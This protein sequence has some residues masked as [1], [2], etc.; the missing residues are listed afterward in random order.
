MDSL[1]FLQFFEARQSDDD[2]KR[3]LE[4][5]CRTCHAHLCDIEPGDTLDVLVSVAEIHASSTAHG[6]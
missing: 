3:D 5:T 2:V 1:Q 6:G 4:L